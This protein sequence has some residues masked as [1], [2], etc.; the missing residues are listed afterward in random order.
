MD[1]L[2]VEE[3]AIAALGYS[4]DDELDSDTIERKV[5]EKFGVSLVQFQAVAEA[6]IYLTI[7]AKTALLGEVFHG[8]VRDGAF[9]VK[10]P[11]EARH[12]T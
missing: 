10:V 12:A 9:I 3:L 8:F 2:E 1:W 7:P 11:V 5:E 6:L 4:L